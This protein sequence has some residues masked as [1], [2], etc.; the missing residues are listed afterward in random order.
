MAQ[1][2]PTYSKAAQKGDHGVELV[3]R[4]VNEKFGWLF[5]RNHQEHDFGIDAQVDVILQDGTVTGQM[6]ALQIKYGASFFNEKSKWGYIFRG[7]QKHF[8]YLSNY[9]IP[10]LILIC[11]PESGDIYWV[12][13]VPEITSRAGNNW[14]IT[15]PFE[16][17]LADSKGDITE[18]LP[19]PADYLSQVA[20]YWMMND[21]IAEHDNFLFIIGRNEIEGLDISEVRSFFDRLRTT[22][23][24]ADHCQGKVE[25]AFHGFDNDPRELFQIPEM[26]K[27]VPVLSDALPELL[28]FARTG[29]RSHT[30]KTIALCLTEVRILSNTPNE[31]NQIPVEV[32]TDKI[33]QFIDSHCSGLNEMTDWLKMSIEENKQIFFGAVRALGFEPPSD[34]A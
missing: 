8:N 28:F 16:H 2:Y 27:F 31:Y 15:I 14:K 18:L 22:R 34:D 7:E 1:G 21:I 33:A 13:F 6:I 3:S 9:P 5:K 30:L 10:V 25:L 29:E 24:L 19:P 11:H 20:K 4:V 12:R 32:T 23:E 26:R 17:K